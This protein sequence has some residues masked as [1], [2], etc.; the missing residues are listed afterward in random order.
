VTSDAQGQ[1]DPPPPQGSGEERIGGWE[2]SRLRGKEHW[3][4]RGETP[5]GAW[6]P[7]PC[8]SCT[9][10]RTPWR[11]GGSTSGKSSPARKKDAQRRQ[12]ECTGW[13]AAVGSGNSECKRRARTVQKDSHLQ[14]ER[15]CTPPAGRACA[16]SPHSLRACLLPGAHAHERLRRATRVHARPRRAPHLASWGSFPECALPRSAAGWGVCCC[17][18]RRRDG[19]EG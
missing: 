11:W 3:P 14:G 16:N 2:S 7:L 17:C 6:H 1:G 18:G 10:S 4:E 15:L 5:G 13:R 9:A 8:A 19:L 12:Y